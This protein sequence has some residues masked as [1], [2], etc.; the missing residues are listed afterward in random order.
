[1]L[2]QVLHKVTTG[3]QMVKLGQKNTRVMQEAF[4]FVV[5]NKAFTTA[6]NQRS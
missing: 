6:N 4:K 1:M 5:Q 3:F 2:K